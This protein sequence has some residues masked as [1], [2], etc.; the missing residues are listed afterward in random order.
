M[1]VI[2]GVF[3]VVV[4]MMVVVMCDGGVGIDVIGYMVISVVDDGGN[5]A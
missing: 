4:V 3:M 5:G 2:I 1:V